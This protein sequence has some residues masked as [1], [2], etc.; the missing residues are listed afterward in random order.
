MPTRLLASA[1]PAERTTRTPN[2]PYEATRTA[3][4]ATASPLPQ[5]FRTV[6]PWIFVRACFSARA[7]SRVIAR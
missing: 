3:I 7:S 5:R 6:L 4:A 2:H 1:P